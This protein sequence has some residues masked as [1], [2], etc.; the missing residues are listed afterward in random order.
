MRRIERYDRR[1]GRP[2]DPVLPRAPDRFEGRRDD[3]HEIRRPPGPHRDTKDRDDR[4]RGT[5]DRG[6]SMRFVDFYL[7]CCGNCHILKI[8][9]CGVFLAA[10]TG[11]LKISTCTIASGNSKGA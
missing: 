5:D 2:I 1:D 7:T 8:I 6:R 4:G 9:F 11:W 3:K 10:F